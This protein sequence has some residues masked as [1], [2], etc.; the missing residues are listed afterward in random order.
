MTFTLRAFV[1]IMTR[2]STYVFFA[3]YLCL[4]IVAVALGTF[5]P[6]IFN[7][8]LEFSTTQSNVYTSAIYFVSMGCYAIWSWHS[9]W[10]RE[11]MW[12]YL[13]PVF[14]AIPCFA[15]WTYVSSHQSFGGIKPIALYGLAFLGNLVSIAQPAALTYRS[16]TLY[17]AAEQAV[18]GATAIAALSIASIIGPQ[19]FPI[20][21]K[22]WYL[23]GFATSC[24][25][26]AFTI[27]GYSSLPLW[28]LWEARRRKQKTGHAMPFRA[29]E[30][31]AHAMVSDG[32][33]IAEQE[34]RLREEKGIPNQEEVIR[35]ED[36]EMIAP[37]GEKL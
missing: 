29:L 5:L 25:C 13:L 32:T 9:D 15:T 8:F 31:A 22:P 24:A 23:D 37:T 19:I 10:T 18:G 21:Q 11:R 6:I 26:L 2:P 35:T 16:S 30:D 33:K 28:L 12:H 27:I 20:P 1:D 7:T 17:G 14:A 4:L 36:V 34:Q 3:S